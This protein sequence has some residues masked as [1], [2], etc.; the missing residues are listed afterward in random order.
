MA[1]K[2]GTMEARF[3]L[4]ALFVFLSYASAA[5]FSNPLKARD[6]SDPHIVY[7]DGFYYL[8]TTTWSNLQVTR[9]TTLG[10]LKTG[11]TKVVWTD[12]NSA[13]CCNVWAPELHK[14]NNTYVPA[15]GATRPSTV[16]RA[17]EL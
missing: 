15:N 6:G 4:W 10:G 9:A 12:S 11:E 13:R 17:T 14:I 1:S 16:G 8:M 7:T 3:S 5:P 2:Q